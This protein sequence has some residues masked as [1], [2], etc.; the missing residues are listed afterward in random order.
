[1]FLDIRNRLNIIENKKSLWNLSIIGLYII[2][3]YLPDITRY[4]NLVMI[5]ICITA[6]CYLVKDFRQV[7]NSLRNSLC[8]SILLFI[9]AMFYS[10]GISIDPALSFK[11]MNKP[12]LNGLLLFSFTLPIVLY[13]E[14]K[15]HIA[16]MILIAFIIGMLA[17]SLTDIAKY[18]IDY[19]STGEMPFSNFNHREFS[20]GFIFYFPVLL[21]TWALWKKHSLLSWLLLLIASAISLFLLLGTLSRGAWVAIVA[22][23]VFIIAINRE[24]KITIAA[25]ICLGLLAGITHWSA[26]SN[27]A[28]KL[29][30]YKLT[31]TDSSHRYSN[32]VQGSAWQLIME[33]PVKGYGFGNKVYHQV[34]NSRVADYPDWTYRTSIGPHNVFLSLWFA[35]GILG[36]ITTLLMTFS[37][38]FT[39]SQIIRQNSGIIRQAGIIILTAFIGIFVVRGMFENAYVNEIGILLGLMIALYS[40][41]KETIIEQKNY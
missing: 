40:A 15:Q 35:G 30:F 16:K 5:L 33:N 9:L 20:Y 34:Y 36:L 4:K 37:A 41:Q 32:G 2:L 17:I 7:V 19:Y 11:E 22:A 3:V 31:Q 27:P 26:A 6:L 28:T 13:Q 10:I 8:L 18:I 1:M 24:W 38:I 21:C 12:I 39:G 25:A 29:L 14:S 23:T